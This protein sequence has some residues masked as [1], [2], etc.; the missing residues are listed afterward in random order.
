MVLR[1]ES[2]DGRRL[3]DLVPRRDP[4]N[5]WALVHI[6]SPR[7][8]FRLV[9]KDSN[10]TYWLAFSEPKEIGPGTL[11]ARAVLQHWYVL[12]GAGLLFCLGSAWDKGAAREV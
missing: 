3:A 11:L 1:I 9:A 12:F 10:T 7:E 8:P 4:G 5:Q 6:P 2:L